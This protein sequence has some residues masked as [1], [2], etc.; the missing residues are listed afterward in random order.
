MTTSKLHS[1]K[2]WSHSVRADSVPEG[3]QWVKLAANENECEA[4]AKRLGVKSLDRLE[5]KLHLVPQNSGH[6]L[7]VDGHLSADVVQ[8]C[9]VTL[10]PVESHIEDDFAAWYADYE[11]AASFT[12]AQH[13]QKARM[14]SEELPIMEEKDDPEPMSEGAI[15]VAELVIQYLSLAINPYPKSDSVKLEGNEKEEATPQGS[16]R[17]NPFA[18]L[19]SW[20]PKD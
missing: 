13:E 15:D 19:K 4:I 2:E 18:A 20:R 5:A 1:N 8:E 6:I 9:V 14:E 11:R 10:Q 16:L 3:G 7:E 12:K 17:L